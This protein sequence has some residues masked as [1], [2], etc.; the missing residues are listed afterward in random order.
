MSTAHVKNKEFKK[1]KMEGYVQAHDLKRMEM[2][3]NA[4]F[5][6]YQDDTFVKSKTLAEL[7]EE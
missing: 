1:Q 6:G 4:I 2:Q 7:R 5:T 3:K